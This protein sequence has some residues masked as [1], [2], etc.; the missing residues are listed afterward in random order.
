M[1]VHSSYTAAISFSTK[2]FSIFLLLCFTLS[3]C[4]RKWKPPG[5]ASTRGQMFACSGSKPW[6]NIL[7]STFI[8]SLLWAHVEG[9]QI[10]HFEPFEVKKKKSRLLFIQKLDQ[11]MKFTSQPLDHSGWRGKRLAELLLR[12]LNRLSACRDTRLLAVCSIEQILLLSKVWRRWQSLA[13][14]S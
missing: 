14:L 1:V 4:R 12:H 3:L 2:M 6:S 5:E 9:V 13:L 11:P 7:C 10:F 8:N